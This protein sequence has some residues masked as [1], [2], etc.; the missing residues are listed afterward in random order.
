MRYIPLFFV[1]FFLV[2]D[3]FSQELDVLPASGRNELFHTFL[4]QRGTEL[5]DE[6]RDSVA[7]ALTSQ[8]ALLERQSQLRADYLSLLGDLP[9]KTPLNAVVVDTI[10]KDGYR[11]ERLHFQSRPDHHVTGN[12]YI[13]DSG[14]APFPAVLIMCGHYPVGKA[15]N[16]YQDLSALF[17]TNG[18]AALIVDPFSQGERNQIQD[19]NTGNLVFAGQSGTSAH[20]RLDVGSMLA[21]G[22][23]VAHALWD[24]HRGVDYLYSRTDVVDT[25]RVGCTG[26]SGGGSQATY[27]AAFDQRLKVA[28]VNSFLMNEETLY[29]TIG[30]QTGSQN[31]SYEGAH[32]IDH[33]DYVTM[34]APKPFIILAATQDFF[35]IDATKETYNEAMNVYTV[36]GAPEK[37]GFFEEN[38][39][40]GYLQ[41]RREKAVQWFRTWF[42]NDTASISEPAFSQFSTSGL[43]ATSTGEVT[44]EFTN[45]QTVTDL[46]VA[47]VDSLAD[48]RADFWAQ[49][50]TD[51]CLNKVRELIRLES[52]DPVQVEET[53]TIDRGDY[54]IIKLK[55]NSGDHVPVTG[56]LFIP[57]S[58]SGPAPAVVYV[59][60][61]GKKRDADPDGVLEQLFVDSGKVVLAI[62]VRGFGETEDNSTKNETK[63]GN[64]E[65]R[66]AVISGY[67]GK[68]L[69][70]QR[71]EDVMKGLDV[72]YSRMEAD[73]NDITLIGIS[74]SGPVVLHAA[75]LDNRVKKT[76]IRNSFESWVPMVGNPTQLNNLTH[77]VPFALKYYDLPDLVNALPSNSVQYF[78]DV[79]SVGIE[80]EFNARQYGFLGQN[81]PNPVEGATIIP[82]ELKQSGEVVLNI[83]DLQGRILSSLPQ[84]RKVS[85]AHQLELHTE[86]LAAGQYFYQ[87]RVDD[88]AL[89]SRKM[90]VKE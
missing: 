38:D 87:L 7:S 36:L 63:H 26:S 62:D 31:L 78:E 35:D 67:I 11:I 2:N 56:L 81:Y 18:I 72:I 71:V 34:F 51:S 10:Q 22:S 77:V 17:A 13:P 33:P 25:T 83:Y 16:L 6:R 12:F 84:G 61:R 59:D 74:R 32:L 76:I 66:N 57:D 28:A 58:L 64:K 3:T 49:N 75:A 79:Y 50:T 14:S 82:Y 60:G 30:P 20:T 27:L 80:D 19:P 68:T 37:I 8:Q 48:H 69:I 43:W 65:H 42:Y 4:M 47:M 89:G 88:I 44:T 39:E 21:G 53:D 73:T 55:I 5:W 70:G 90:I 29:S 1:L 15:I 54:S 41:P 23:V 86:K 24:N 9:E 46:N 52:Y 45:E 85:G 40:H